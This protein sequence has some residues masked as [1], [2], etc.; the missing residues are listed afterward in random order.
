V[1]DLVVLSKFGKLEVAG[2]GLMPAFRAAVAAG[3]PVVTTVS[4]LHR[5]TWR[6]FAPRVVALPATSRALDDWR[7]AC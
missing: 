2:G 1:S 3:K 5:E 7:A 4:S 6:A